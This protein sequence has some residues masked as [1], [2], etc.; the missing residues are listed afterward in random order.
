MSKFAEFLKGLVWGG[1]VGSALVLLLTPYSGEEL[2]SRITGFTQN[3]RTEVQQAGLAKREELEAQ[4]KQLR[5][6]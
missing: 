4:L 6:G 5:S 3:V 1:L 2:K